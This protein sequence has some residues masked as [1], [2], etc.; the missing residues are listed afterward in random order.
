VLVKERNDVADAYSTGAQA[1]A[2]GPIRVYGAMAEQLLERSPIPLPGARLLDLGTGTGAASRPA[3][4]A[5]ASVTA[6]DHAFGMLQTDRAARPPGLVAD[7]VALPVRRGA[8]D[9]VVAAFS[10]N[11]LEDPAA[12][13]REAAEALSDGGFLL[14]STYARDDDHPA[15]HA[16]EEALQEFGWE[17]PPWYP[18]VKAAMAA[19]GTTRDAAAAV[20][21]GGMEPVSVEHCRL[22]FPELGPEALVRWRLGMA[23]AAPFVGGLDDQERD[24]LARRAVELLG[25]DPEPLV[26]SVIFIVARAH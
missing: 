10:L 16:A 2:D 17:M 24:A 5:G 12:G 1:W 7:A 20:E 26:R 6:V 11:H 23:Q 14:A 21:R 13:V 22:L 4:T 15:K 25:P 9:L 18:Q 3:V 8:F 19:W